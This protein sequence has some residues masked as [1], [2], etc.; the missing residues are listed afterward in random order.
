[1]TFLLPR[2]GFV[3]H[4]LEGGVVLG[5][6]GIRGLAAL[7]GLAGV[8]VEVLGLG[9]VEAEHGLEEHVEVD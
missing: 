1:M 9:G 3:M 7:A 8:A 5:I 2:T 6:E 4:R